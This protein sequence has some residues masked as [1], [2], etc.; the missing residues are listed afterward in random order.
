MGP[1]DTLPAL[2]TD[3]D[4]LTVRL[5]G[6][7][8]ILVRDMLGIT[9]ANAALSAEVAPYL[10]LFNGFSTISDL[11]TVMMRR[12]GGSLVFRSE[13]ERIVE[14]LSLLGV[15]QTEAYRREKEKIVRGFTESPEREALLAGTSYPADPAAL[16]ALLDRILS[17]PAPSAEF[18]SEPPCALAAPHIDLRVSERTYSAAYRA[19]RGSSAPASILLLGTGHALGENRYCISGKTFKTPLGRIPADREAASR[20][21]QAAGGALAPDDFV[22][23][24]EHSLEF[25]LLFLQRLYPMETIPILPVLCGQMEDLFETVRS[26]LEAPEIASFVEAVASWLSGAPGA[27]LLVAGVDLSHVGPKFG[28][29]RSGREL[30]PAF[31]ADDRDILDA[32]TAGDASALFLAG[33]RTRNRYRICG[34]SALWTLLAVLPG[35]RGTVLDYDVWHE[36]P[37]RSAVSFAAVAFTRGSSRE[38]LA[39]SEAP[40]GNG[41]GGNPG[42]EGR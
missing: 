37:T 7:D 36:E 6:R 30:E 23:R 27:K 14:D 15:L 26:P 1:M 19:I 33:A 17:L 24:N 11:Q 41:G 42:V 9:A 4:L 8:V 20:I 35:V 16:A 28:D 22:H 40:P 18:Q 38:P 21:R 32:L 31:R 39:V 3:I 2:R 29:P 10:P 12:H 13:A 34:F 5:E 25:Q